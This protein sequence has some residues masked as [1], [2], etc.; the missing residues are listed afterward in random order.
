MIVIEIMKNH[1]HSLKKSDYI[2]I[3]NLRD[4][5]HSP[6]T[7]TSEKSIFSWQDYYGFSGYDGGDFFLVY[8]SRLHRF[9]YPFGHEEHG[10]MWLNDLN[11]PQS[12]KNFAFLNKYQA[13]RLNK[14]G[15][16][17]DIDRD[18][19]EYIYETEALALR[20]GNI[21]SNF[22]RKCRKFSEKYPYTVRMIDQEWLDQGVYDSFEKQLPENIYML[23][24]YTEYEMTGIEIRWQNEQ[25]FLFGYENTPDIFTMTGTDYTK[26]FGPSAVAACIY[27]MARH[28]CGEYQYIN[29]EEDMGIK[30][31]RRMKELYLPVFLM[32]AYNADFKC[33]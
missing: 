32:E 27:E 10:F 28:L 14:K 9:L 8:S 22:K 19:S 24:H 31:L 16:T 30:G 33:H 17:V 7:A 29:L 3:H 13:E 15:Y 21:S 26:G 25:A 20:S 18:A 2:R 1:F 5:Q 12:E 6:L 23:K 11:W 4:I